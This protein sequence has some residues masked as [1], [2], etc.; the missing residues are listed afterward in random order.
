[1]EK[2]ILLKIYADW[3]HYCQMMQEQWD[4]LKMQN[5]SK[6]D[7]DIV[8]IESS[9]LNNLKKF[10]KSHKGQNVEYSGFPTIA[11]YHNGKV[12]YYKGERDAKS[13]MA[14]AKTKLQS[15]KTRKNK[16]PTKKRKRRAKQTKRRLF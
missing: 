15:T 16:K 9:D 5:T 6:S 10:N 11:K 3:C 13:M 14:W 12:E 7:I 4:L 8:E 2:P 1:M